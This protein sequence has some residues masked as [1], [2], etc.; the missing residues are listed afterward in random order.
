MGA[1]ETKAEEERPR[2]TRW[3][4]ASLV[5]CVVGCVL[6]A[7]AFLFAL[8]VA[9][10]YCS[11]VCWGLSVVC[12]AVALAK[13]RIKRPFF[14]GVPEAISGI[15]VSGWAIIVLGGG[16]FLI[17]LALRGEPYDESAPASVIAKIENSCGFKFPENMGSLRAADGLGPGVPPKPYVCIV[18]FTTDRHGLAQLRDSLSKLDYYTEEFSAAGYDPRGLSRMKAP[19]WYKGEMTKGIVYRG[20]GWGGTGLILLTVAVESKEGDKIDVYMEGVGGAGLKEGQ[21]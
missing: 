21:D 7:F 11:F 2:R 9:A 15:C 8:T 16:S 19:E 13:I 6:F 18:R 1:I 10:A 4:I 14:K 12:G 5:S 3:A 17:Y 20:S